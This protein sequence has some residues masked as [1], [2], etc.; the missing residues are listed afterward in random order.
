MFL[1]AQ[2]KYSYFSLHAQ[3]TS[4]TLAIGFGVGVF[5]LSGGHLL[6]SWIFTML[7]EVQINI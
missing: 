1:Q 5:G 6:D 4:E 2:I 7:C 3:S